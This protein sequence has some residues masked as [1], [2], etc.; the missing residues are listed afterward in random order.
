MLWF[1]H[2]F[3]GA[4]MLLEDLDGQPGLR[5]RCTTGWHWAMQLV[6]SADLQQIL[7]ELLNGRAGQILDAG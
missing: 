6:V 2:C 4:S 7:V 1:V 3:G 5:I